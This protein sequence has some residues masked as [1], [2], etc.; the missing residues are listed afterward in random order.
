MAKKIL[1]IFALMLLLVC[2]LTS[3][4]HKHN[5]TEVKVTTP[6]TCATY[7]VETHTCECGK[8]ITVEISPLTEHNYVE[9]VEKEPT[10]GHFGQ[11]DKKFTCSVCGYTYYDLDSIPALEHTFLEATCTMPKK[12][13]VCGES[14]GD[15]LGHDYSESNGA[16][17]RCEYGAK[18]ILPNL[19]VT[20]RNTRYNK[21][22][23]IESIKIERI[24]YYSQTYYML[25]FIV[26]STY[27]SKGTNYSDYASFGWKLYDEDGLVVTSGT[28]VTEGSIMVGEK[29]K[30]IEKFYVG[31]DEYIQNGKTYHLE[32]INLS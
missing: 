22:C 5:Y 6:A 17:T 7:G 28:G 10:C 11:G 4:G 12:C 25:T 21:T 27:H 13:S 31:E 3:C 26:E 23:K 29:S 1:F 15:I 30:A 32:L 2:A 18:F 8:S 19:P 24:P 16:C 20:I 9:S 14:E